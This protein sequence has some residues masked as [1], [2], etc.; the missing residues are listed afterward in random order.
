MALQIQ[1]NPEA[2]P[3]AE[4]DADA[5][6]GY[7]GYNG[8]Y[9]HYGY[10]PYSY[11]GGYYQRRSN[12]YFYKPQYKQAYYKKAYASPKHFAP[13][14]P[15]APYVKS[16][17]EPTNYIHHEAPVAPP[18]PSPSPA[19][20]QPQRSAPYTA[21]EGFLKAFNAVPAV[22]EDH[23]IAYNAAPAPA[24]RQVENQYYNEEPVVYNEPRYY[25]EPAPAIDVIAAAPEVNNQQ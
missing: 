13:S 11:G 15:A 14:P 20:P 1:A 10:R 9:R 16:A 8:G 4:A 6:Y 17:P 21:S 3:E 19:P 25:D 7:G 22:P 5:Y 2:K 12:P 18:P 23:V 24:P